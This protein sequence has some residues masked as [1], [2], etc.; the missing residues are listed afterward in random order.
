SQ[1]SL[2]APFERK[3]RDT[4]RGSGGG[5]LDLIASGRKVAD[6]ARDLEVSGQT[7][8]NWRRQDRID[9]GETPGLRS[10]E[11]AERKSARWRIHE[12]ETELAATSPTPATRPVR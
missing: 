3:S 2:R 12:L 4:H 5:V 9:R 6:L 11:I 8:Y 1:A 10:P 7:I